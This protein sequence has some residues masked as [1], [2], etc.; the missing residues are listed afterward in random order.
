VYALWDSILAVGLCLGAVT[1]FRRFFNRPGRFGKFLSQHSYA[2]YIIHIPAV[3]FIAV[4][5]KGIQLEPLM[6]FG[7]VSIIAVPVCF[8]VAFVVRKIPGAAR[9]I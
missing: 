4:A 1:L 3:V 6:K 5:M 8:A 7:L 2:V 9:I